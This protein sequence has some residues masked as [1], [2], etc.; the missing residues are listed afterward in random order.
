MTIAVDKLSLTLS[1]EHGLHLFENGSKLHLTIL[2][3]AEL[4]GGGLAPV[5][6]PLG[7]A[8]VAKGV[9]THSDVIVGF[10]SYHSHETVKL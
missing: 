7:E 9:L 8:L 5:Q 10:N 1:S 2:E 6:S 3:Q 4:P